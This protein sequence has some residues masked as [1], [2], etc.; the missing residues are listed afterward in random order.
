MQYCPLIIAISN[1]HPPYCRQHM[2]NK[3]GE[4]RKICLFFH[5][6]S[7]F[8]FFQKCFIISDKFIDQVGQFGDIASRHVYQAIRLLICHGEVPFLC[9]KLINVKLA[10][11]VSWNKIEGAIWNMETQCSKCVGLK[12]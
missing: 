5:L 10:S 8:F 11:G 7:N 3:P 6:L 9:C 4:V 2:C 12:S 1:S